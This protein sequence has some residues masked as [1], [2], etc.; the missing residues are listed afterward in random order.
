MFLILDTET[1]GFPRDWKKPYTDF[2][3]WP[4]IIEIAWQLYDKEQRLV[5]C[6]SFLIKKLNFILNPHITEIT[7]IKQE[8]L[9]EYGLY[10]DEVIMRL[11]NSAKQAKYI[12]CHNASFD[13]NIVY[14]ELIRQSFDVPNE[15]QSHKWLCT[16]ELGTDICKLPN[17]KGKGYKWPNLTQLYLTLF[18]KDFDNKHSALGDVQATSECFFEILKRK[19]N[20]L[21][22]M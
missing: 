8:H 20:L 13:K 5:L 10:I 18:D 9:K 21:N 2:D 4:E 15:L 17:P 1:T 3:N 14:S 19:P 12:I 11:I 6:N 7:G 22:Y 16:K